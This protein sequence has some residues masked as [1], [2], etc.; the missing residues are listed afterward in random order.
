[1]EQNMIEGIN[2]K[3]GLGDMAG[4]MVTTNQSLRYLNNGLM[5]QGSCPVDNRQFRGNITVDCLKSEPWQEDSWKELVIG[6]NSKYMMKNFLKC[7]RCQV[8][9]LD[10]VTAVKRQ[11]GEPLNWLTR[12]GR[13]C[14]GAE[15]N[16]YDSPHY[17]MYYAPNQ[18]NEQNE[19]VVKIGD[20]VYAKF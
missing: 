17:G 15:L 1:M 11:D 7:T 13:M 8:T 19:T 16:F 2:Y 20:P 4:L 9:T 12:F 6:S 10:P 3:T 14:S 18:S 5:K